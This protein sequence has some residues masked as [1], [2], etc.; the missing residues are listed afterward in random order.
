MTIMFFNILPVLD[1]FFLSA[2][3]SS[4]IKRLR[5]EVLN[6]PKSLA[7]LTQEKIATDKWLFLTISDY[8]LDN[9]TF[10]FQKI[11]SG[12]IPASG[13]Y[14]YVSSKSLLNEQK[15]CNLVKG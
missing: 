3:C 14:F 8:F 12:S 7:W 15:G 13:K 11:D 4:F 2:V 9:H 1:N 10:I 5:F 6:R